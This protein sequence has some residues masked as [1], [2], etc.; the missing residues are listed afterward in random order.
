MEA[1]ESEMEGLLNNP[2][3]Y[4]FDQFIRATNNNHIR[5]R[6]FPSK[7]DLKKVNLDRAFEIY[8][9]RF[10]DCTDFKFV[11]VGNI[12]EETHLPLIAKYLGTLPGKGRKEQ[13]KDII[14]PNPTKTQNLTFKKGLAPQSNVGIMFKASFDGTLE[15][16]IKADAMGR[17]L[18]IMVR[19][20]LREDKGGVYSP[21]V[22][23]DV[24]KGHQNNVNTMVY[25]Q[26]APET[27]DM[28]IEAV[29]DE[30][31]SIQ[32][33][34]GGEENL[35][36]VQEMMLRERETQLQNNAFWRSVFMREY[37]GTGKISDY[38]KFDEI[39]RSITLDD[40]KNMAKTS[41]DLNK[42]LTVKGEAEESATAP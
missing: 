5:K 9:E 41:L 11:F 3:Y 23:T 15:N 31:K 6:I 32:A 16:A 39:V 37:T 38:T 26:C 25:F 14:I 7:E 4:F 18:D 8:K 42:V 12:D 30:V 35:K 2:Q 19:E 1:T 36:K 34:G 10:H 20:N 40:I 29:K 33:N 28:L 13:A 22:N 24:E 27:A 17:I 21:S